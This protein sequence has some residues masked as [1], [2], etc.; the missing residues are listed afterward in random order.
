MSLN[1]LL[2][3][4]LLAFQ[5]PG[6][7]LDAVLQRATAYVTKYEAELGNLIATENYIQIW[8]N[9]RLVRRGQRRTSSDVLIIDVG[10]DWAALRKVNSVDGLKVKQSSESFAG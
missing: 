2:V 1:V 8:T 10:R 7:E 4:L 6:V 3:M 5:R 9:D